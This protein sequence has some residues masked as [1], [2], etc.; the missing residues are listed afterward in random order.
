MLEIPM[1]P[2]RLTRC[3]ENAQLWRVFSAIG[4]VVALAN[5]GQFEKHETNL[6]HGKNFSTITTA[7]VLS[8]IGNG[9]NNLIVYVGIGR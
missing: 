6:L 5:Y 3:G 2:G 9:M 7:I 1:R 4:R 8:Y